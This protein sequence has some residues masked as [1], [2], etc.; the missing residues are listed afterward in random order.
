MRDGG[1]GGEGGRALSAL[2]WGLVGRLQ[3][4]TMF[5]YRHA[6]VCENFGGGGSSFAKGGLAGGGGP[7]TQKSKS[8]YKSS[9]INNSFCKISFFPVTKSGCEGGWGGGG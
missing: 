1:G 2:A 6:T 8:L 9:Q 4:G 7:G 3:G 5:G